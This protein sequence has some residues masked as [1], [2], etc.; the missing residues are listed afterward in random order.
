[1]RVLMASR[2]HSESE[3][4]HLKQTYKSQTPNNHHSPPGLVHSTKHSIRL[5]LN[6]GRTN[7]EC[8][9][10]VILLSWATSS[11]CVGPLGDK[12]GRGVPY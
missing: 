5:V 11:S 8:A 9:K 2:M 12:W 1:M 6:M 7:S 4:N 10:V 3:N